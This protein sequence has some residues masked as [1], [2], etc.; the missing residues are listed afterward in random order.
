MHGLHANLPIRLIALN[1]KEFVLF[2]RIGDVAFREGERLVQ[3]FCELIIRK[4]VR[5][6]DIYFISFC[7]ELDI[8]V[9]IADFICLANLHLLPNCVDGCKNG[10]LHDAIGGGYE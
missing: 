4:I 7:L 10:G 6:Q 1:E 3:V 5:N 2:F 9:N 8:R